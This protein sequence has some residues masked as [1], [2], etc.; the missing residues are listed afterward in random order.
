LDIGCGYGGMLVALAPMF[1]DKL[2]LGLEIRV[3]VSD[4]VHDRILALRSQHEDQYQNIAV[5]RTNAMK[6]LPNF[7]RKG[8]LSKLFF[9]YPDP[10]FKKQKHKWRIINEQL[11]AEYAYVMAV[12]GIVYTI[13]DVIGLHTWMVKYLEEHPLFVRSSLFR[14]GR[15]GC[16]LHPLAH[17]AQ[18]IY[19]IQCVYRTFTDAP[20]PG[21]VYHNDGAYR[22]TGQ[23]VRG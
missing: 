8:Q 16:M 7:F 20:P 21:F 1:P 19:Y 6:Y 15:G 13:T 9:L 18:N 12:G 3:K 10:H 23:N 4:Y 11:L 22:I 2:M 5:L 14:L 17:F